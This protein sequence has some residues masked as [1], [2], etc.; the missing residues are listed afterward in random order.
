MFT[1]EGGWESTNDMNRKITEEEAECPMYACVQSRAQL[2]DTAWAVTCQAPLSM[3][4]SRQ[5][6]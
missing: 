5:E 4:F 3:E 1:V 6:S 2:F